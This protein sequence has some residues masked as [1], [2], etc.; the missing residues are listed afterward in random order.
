MDYVTRQFI[1]LTKKLRKELRAAIQSLDKG[2]T[3]QS[4]AI[5]EATEAAKQRQQAPTLRAELHVPQSDR[6]KQETNDTRKTIV[7]YW[8]AYIEIVGIVILAAYT[9]VTALQ[10]REMIKSTGAAEE[11]AAA[12]RDAANI[13]DAT[14]KNA[15]KQFRDEQRPYIWSQAGPGN[16]LNQFIDKFTDRYE[17]DIVVH[18]INAG[19]SPALDTTDTDSVTLAG[20]S[21]QVEKESCSYVPQYSH[22]STFM[23]PEEHGTVPTGPFKVLTEEQYKLWQDGKWWIRVVG[24]IKYHDIFQPRLDPYET[25]Y[26]F[27]LNPHGLPIL[28]CGCNSSMK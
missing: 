1:N 19:R 28:V 26:C 14:L 22:A 24:A 25:R 13:A 6:Y 12:A 7:E 16:P 8:K 11:A 10:L 21:A 23:M 15:Q 27:G 20:P 3:K 5:Q 4:E 9:T 18:I 17:T 2:L